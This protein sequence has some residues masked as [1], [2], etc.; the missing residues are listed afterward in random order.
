ME[1]QLKQ[2]QPSTTTTE[3]IP[4]NL[5]IDKCLSEPPILRIAAHE[6]GIGRIAKLI[7]PQ[8]DLMIR[9]L[10][11]KMDDD[12]IIQ[13]C[14]DF[15]E[16]FN[17]ETI[18]DILMVIEAGRKNMYPNIKVY[19]TVTMQ[20]LSSWMKYH[21]EEKYTVKENNHNRASIKNRKE[22][23]VVFNRKNYDSDKEQE[24]DKKVVF[25]TRQEY[26]DWVEKGLKQQDEIEES[27]G[28]T[29]KEKHS[30][31]LD[32]LVEI[33]VSIGKGGKSKK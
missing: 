28:K 11:C 32:R 2:I 13:L 6:G 1:K 26:I 30:K 18:P 21:L 31:T 4:K 14:I 19:G 10:G 24:E 33:S 29:R 16:K 3:L 17:Y 12:L 5:S 9:S 15:V 23:T 7:Y 27:I 25:N 20:I 22:E 8:M